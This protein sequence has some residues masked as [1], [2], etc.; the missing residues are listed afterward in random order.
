MSDAD[1]AALLSQAAT[2]LEGRN[3]AEAEQILRRCEALQPDD[4]ALLELF[5]VLFHL[6][7]R[8]VEAER[9]CRRALQASPQSAMLHRRL[10]HALSAQGREAEAADAFRDACASAPGDP[11]ARFELATTLHRRGI[12]AEAEAAYREVLALDAEFLAAMQGLAVVLL[13]AGRLNE[14]EEALLRALSSTRDPSQQYDLLLALAEVLKGA[15]KHADAAERYAQARRIRPDQYMLDCSRAACLQLAGRTDEAVEAYRAALASAPLDLAIHADLNELLYRSGCDEAFLRSYDEAARHV[16]PTPLLQT[17]KGY[18]LMQA[19]RLDGAIAAFQQALAIDRSHA[20]ATAGLGAAFAGL[21][22]FE[23]AIEAQQRAAAL[24]P[25]DPKIFTGLGAT[26]LRSGDLAGAEMAVGRA[27]A[28]SPADQSALATLGLIWRA[29]EDPREA[30]LNSY[31]HFVRAFDLDPPEGF[32]RM[33]DFNHELALCLR[34]LHTDAREHF[35]QT[36]RGGTRSAGL[37]FGAGHDL[38]ERLRIRIEQAVQA[39]VQSTPYTPSHPFLGRRRNGAALLGSWSSRMCEG[40]FHKNHI[41]PGA[42]AWISATYYVCVP[43]AAGGTEDRQGW[44]KFGEP[45]PEFGAG[46]GVRHAI[47]PRP[48]RLV[49]FPSYFWHGTYPFAGE[50]ERT[51]IAFDVASH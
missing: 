20:G 7:G 51:T 5:A 39:Y 16:A 3:L 2:Q 19:G 43:D 37:L 13:A 12:G 50:G 41:H 38:V 36:L 30:A 26:L 48:G 34:G 8:F 40:G 29:R 49:L 31:E 35:N 47:Q 14:A 44:L 9:C 42:G 6:R 27:I 33:D 28:L 32:A 23:A 22:R 10:G 15:R 45:S 1:F 21:G 24:T 46:Y 18:A 25:D 4:P 11:S 17:S